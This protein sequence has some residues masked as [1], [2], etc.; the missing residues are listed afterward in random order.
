MSIF[1]LKTQTSDLHLGN[2]GVSKSAYEMIAPSRDVSDTSFPNGPISFKY[3]HSSTKWWI[4]SKS[5]IRTRMSI[6][7]GDGTQLDN[8]ENIAP[9]MNLTSNLFQS[10]EFRIQDKVV[11]RCSD[12]VNAIDTLITRQNKSSSWFN[13]F[14]A[15][16]NFWEPDAVK[17]KNLITSDG[18]GSHSDS[19]ETIWTPA[20][21]SIFNIEHAIPGGANFELLLNPN[22]LATYQNLCVD[23]N[24]TK[25]PYASA[26]AQGD[27]KVTIHSMYLY[28]H[29]VEAERLENVSYLLDL[30]S[31]RLQT[32]GALSASFSQKMFDIS[33]S[34]YAI[35]VFYQDSRIA[36]DSAVPANKFVFDKTA[37]NHLNRFY[38]NYASQSFPS[39]DYDLSWGGRS[40][41]LNQLYTNTLINNGKYLSNEG[42]ET[43]AEFLNKGM[44]ITF[45]CPKDGSD[46]STKLTVNAGFEATAT[47]V[48]ALPHARLCV[49]DS[50]REVARIVI[51]DGRCIDVQVE[52]A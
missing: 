4:P 8:A 11:S 29:T 31:S 14:G 50:Y 45:L 52:Q 5:Y 15:S 28:I 23:T 21:L 41:F 46:R 36:T 3:Q 49:C 9:A 16:S 33:P 6:T 12:Y 24:A 38:L 7:K 51:K 34:T 27:F 20:C 13:S 32:D 1:D 40:D 10:M 30:Q 37:Q 18:T 47:V 22:N 42:V 39:P 17:R 43:Q 25:A 19:F 26:T 35:T 44:Y 48:G 2:S